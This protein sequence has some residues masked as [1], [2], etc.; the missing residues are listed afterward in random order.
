MS[1]I[2]GGPMF[3]PAR[4]SGMEKVVSNSGSG[5]HYSVWHLDSNRGRPDPD[6][7]MESLKRLFPDGT[8]NDLNF[9]LFSTSGVHGCYTTIE[10]IEAGLER[11]GDDFDPGDDWPADWSGDT[12]TV[13]V[14]Q[15]RIVCL[16]CGNVRV[17]KADI[18][19]LKGLRASSQ[20]AVMLIGTTSDDDV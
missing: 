17:R 4:H 2:T 8:A 19:W 18:A 9:V 16:R 1:M 7:G 3:E 20:D 12:L 10:Q 15:P 5:A 13:L 14:V 6:I 11:Y